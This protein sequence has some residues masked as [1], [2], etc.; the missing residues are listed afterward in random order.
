MWPFCITHTECIQ[1]SDIQ[2]WCLH[3]V[4]TSASQIE[5]PAEISSSKPSNQPTNRITHSIAISCLNPLGEACH[6]ILKIVHCVMHM[7]DVRDG[8]HP[9]MKTI[10][11]YS[12]KHA[13]LF[14]SLHLSFFN[15][16]YSPAHTYTHT[17]THTHTRMLADADVHGPLLKAE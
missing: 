7:R 2:Q 17:H 8:M 1:L 4:V 16:S 10:I 6:H 12:H 3:G 13:V 14:L 5:F 15:F 9:W 11:F